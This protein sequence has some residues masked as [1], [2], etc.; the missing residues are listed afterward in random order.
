M[1]IDRRRAVL[2]AAACATPA[3]PGLAA[4]EGSYPA[5]PIR[6]V[7][8]FA[9]GGTTD[10]VARVVAEPLAR[11]LGQPVVVDNRGGGGG[12]IGA[13]ETVRAPADGYSLG[14]AT[15]STVATNPAVNP[16]LAYSPLTDF[17]PITNLAATPSVIAVTR[18]F[19]AHDYAGFVAEL[20]RSAGKYSFSSSGAGGI[21]HLMMEMFKGSTGTFITHIPYR[22]AGPAL[23]DTVAGQVAM[24]LDQLPSALPFIKSGQ[25]VPI[26]VAAPRRLE[27]LPQV[28]TFAEVG[29]PGLNR[30]AFYG[31][32]G[33]RG[34]PA[35]VV[36]T[37]NTALVKVLADPS[38][39]KRIEDTGSFVVGNSA[40]DFAIQI[41]EEFAVYR[42]VVQRQKITLD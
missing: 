10:V 31:V 17:T 30:M 20:R 7:V 26:V 6:L 36:D 18:S 38:V 12:S 13:T 33:P 41:R 19:P 2:W 29:L 34:L 27:V 4:A 23:T 11:L 40:A 22:G 15:V 14:I 3:L 37:L 42:A 28:P 35:N 24:T 8:P 25:L 32:V 9:P 5:R 21:Q 1:Q 16:R 39:K